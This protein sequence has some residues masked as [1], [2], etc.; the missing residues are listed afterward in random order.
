MSHDHSKRVI[1]VTGASKGLGLAIVQLLL[2]FSTSSHSNKA[3]TVTTP[4][5]VDILSQAIKVVAVSR[6]ETDEL[7]R[8]AKEHS[9]DVEIVL[10]DVSDDS[11]NQKAVG[12]AVEK[13][14]QL[15]AL[16]LNAGTLHPLGRIES[17]PLDGWRKCF[18]INFFSLVSILQHATPH[19]RRAAETH[20]GGDAAARGVGSEEEHER[21]GPRVVMV[22][23]GAAV[24]GTA[25]WAVYNASKAAMN[26]LART[27]ANEEKGIATYAVRPGVVDTD[28][29]LGD[30]P[31]TSFVLIWSLRSC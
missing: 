22:S 29:S 7:K 13:F 6:S 12:V 9:E 5:G 24:G 4:S 27:F 20:P 1:I 2:S 26:S 25:G 11:I 3:K 8:I 10:G 19:L 23:S 31:H 16:I 17:T 21:V 14:G 15:D 18:E 30:F 28:V